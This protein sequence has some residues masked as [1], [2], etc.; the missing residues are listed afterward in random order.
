[1]S[2]KADS[3]ALEHFVTTTK[4][5]S[6]VEW[7]AR[8]SHSKNLMALPIGTACCSLE[9]MATIGAKYDLESYGVE[10]NR[11]APRESDLLIV[12]GTITEKQAPILKRIYEQ[13]PS[14]KW[15]IAMGACAASGGFYRSYNV[16][17]GI[18][19]YFPVDVYIPGCPPTPEALLEGIIKIKE[20]I[21]KG[22]CAQGFSS[23]VNR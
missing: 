18:D 10:V 5:D 4:A 20:R 22:V 15:V 14:P 9:Y 23:E 17:Q 13:M 16:V 2:I 1:M 21:N 3:F 11:F 12:A 8:W 7:L 6:I 19:K